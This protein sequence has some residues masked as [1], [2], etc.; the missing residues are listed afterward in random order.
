M[1]PPVGLSRGRTEPGIDR[2]G[3]LL[4]N[5]MSEKFTVLLV[6]GSLREQSTNTAVLHTIVAIAPSDVEA[7]VYDGLAGLPHFNPDDEGPLIPDRVADL[8]AQIR[9]SD[10]VMFSTPEYAGALPGSF[11]NLL[12]WAVGDELPGSLNGKRVAWINASPRGAALA[13]ESL[14]RVLGYLGAAIV[15]AACVTVPLT[16]DQ[17]GDDGLIT[18]VEIRQRLGAALQD[19]VADHHKAS[20]SHSSPRK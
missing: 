9:A 10:A 6:S 2:S 15:E 3:P 20:A 7:V 14:R 8:R 18:S 1:V 5:G 13:H 12:D 19:L 11:K 4:T 16:R 17:V